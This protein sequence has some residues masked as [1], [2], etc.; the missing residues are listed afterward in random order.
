MTI[1]TS[2]RTSIK[3]FEI[4]SKDN[5]LIETVSKTLEGF[6]YLTESTY[7]ILHDAVR[8]V[9]GRAFEVRGVAFERRNP[10]W[11]ECAHSHFDCNEISDSEVEITT[12]IGA[13]RIKA[14]RAQRG[15]LIRDVSIGRG[16]C[17]AGRIA[18]ETQDSKP[19]RVSG[20][21]KLPSK[22]GAPWKFQPDFFEYE[23]GTHSGYLGSPVILVEFA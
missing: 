22:P 16:S 20:S 12:P 13:F 17:S 19:V 1:R 14:R 8:D 10:N 5:T 21:L 7:P 3:T 15:D 4:Y 11:L 9:T 18:Q 23:D 2:I 6:D